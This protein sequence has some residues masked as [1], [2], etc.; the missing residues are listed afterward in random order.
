MDEFR[1][2]LKALSKINK[3]ESVQKT[4]EDLLDI[5]LGSDPVT[6]EKTVDSESEL[7]SLLQELDESIKDGSEAGARA[8]IGKTKNALLER[9]VLCKAGK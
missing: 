3:I 9:N 2:R 5:A 6:N 4:L 1:A 7:L 8:A